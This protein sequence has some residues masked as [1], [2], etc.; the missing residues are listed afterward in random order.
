MVLSPEGLVKVGHGK[1]VPNLVLLNPLNSLLEPLLAQRKLLH[2]GRNVLVASQLQHGL[3]LLP[4][5]DMAACQLGSIACK[6]ARRHLRQRLIT[7]ANHVELAANIEDAQIRRQIKLVGSISAVEDKVKLESPFVGPAVL[8]C[9]DDAR[10]PQCFGILL[11]AGR[12]RQRVHFRTQRLSPL[13]PQVAEAAN[14]DDGDFAAG[15]DTGAYE[16][17]VRRQPGA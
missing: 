4:I 7:Q 8:V 16:W 3:H 17:G 1:P 2:H 12:M 13:Q 6:S 15:L 9:I 10:G 11:L 14:A 5:A